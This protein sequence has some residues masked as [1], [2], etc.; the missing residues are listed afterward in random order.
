MM[1]FITVSASGVP[2]VASAKPIVSVQ[3]ETPPGGVA[4][5]AS[6]HTPNPQTNFFSVRV[7]C[8]IVNVVF[9]FH[10]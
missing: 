9:G 6:V 5:V 4:V 8:Q 7:V 3:P 1:M 2:I 10:L